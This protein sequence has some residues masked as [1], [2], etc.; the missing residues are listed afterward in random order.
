VWA[1]NAQRVSAVGDFN[2]WSPD[3]HLLSPCGESGVWAKFIP[4]VGAGAAYQ[5][6]LVSCHQGYQTDKMDPM[7]FRHGLVSNL[8]SYIWDLQYDWRDVQWLETRAGRNNL[9]AAISIYEVHLGSWMRV[10]EQ[11][12]RPLSYREAGPKL[13]EYALRLGFTHV[14]LMPQG[15]Q[16]WV[17]DLNHFYAAEQAAASSDALAAGFEWIDPQDAEQSTLSWLRRD[18][19]RRELLLAICNFTRVVRRN[20]RVGVPRG[21]WWQELLNSD[22]KEYGGSGQGNLGGAATSPF[23]S[24]GR[25]HTLTITLPPL[26]LVVFRHEGVS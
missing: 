12:N 22:A 13:A 23:S 8:A 4:D 14:E 21:G 16:V 18:L 3:T 26:A 2:G 15:V 5:Y 17:K 24:Y 6:H 19:H 20:F 25:P 9:N 11:A 10:P 1:P 7:G